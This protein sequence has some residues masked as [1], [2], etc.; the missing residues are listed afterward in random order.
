MNMRENELSVRDIV[1]RSVVPALDET[2]LTT[3]YREVVSWS[4]GDTAAAGRLSGIRLVRISTELENALAN[5]LFNARFVATDLTRLAEIQSALL[6][7]LEG[8]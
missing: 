2:R 1:H 5:Q 8:G 6:T 3:P 4:L 7:S